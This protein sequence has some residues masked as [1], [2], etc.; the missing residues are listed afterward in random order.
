MSDRVLAGGLESL[1]A[2]RQHIGKREPAFFLDFDGT[3]APLT[4]RPELAEL[5]AKTR[6]VL[7]ALAGTH[8][9]CVVS[10]R[11]LVDLQH[12]VDLAALYYGADHGHRV[13][14]PP[15]TGIDFE[16]GP[17]DRRDLEAA[18]Y[19]L[20]QRLRRVEGA[21]VEAKGVSLSVHYRLVAPEERPLVHEIMSDIAKTLPGFRLATGKLAHDLVPDSDW[22]KG[23]AMVWLLQRLR[24]SRKSTCP[25]CLG[26]DLTDER[27]F[28]AAHGWGVS[29]VVGEPEQDTRASYALSGPD[30]VA[31]FLEEFVTHPG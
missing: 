17:E 15:G 3:L 8:L 25:V 27:L 18:A 13:L 19:E 6:R 1:S 30:E 11:G 20:D 2:I 28:A 29:L 10:G 9:V 31:V 22:D 14:G 23:R 12:R 24:R 26:D 7:A 16:I 5:P 21:V 4:S